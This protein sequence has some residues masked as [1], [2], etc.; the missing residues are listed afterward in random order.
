[1]I[2]ILLL[3]FIL[4]FFSIEIYI[5][6]PIKFLNDQ[7]QDICGAPALLSALLRSAS[8]AS[9]ASVISL[10]AGDQTNKSGE[11][12]VTRLSSLPSVA[13]FFSS[14]LSQVDARSKG[15]SKQSDVSGEGF[16]KQ[17]LG[18]SR[19]YTEAACRLLDRYP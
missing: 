10:F 4:L 5:Y 16:V 12:E 7:R 2:I 3:L 17:L 13:S 9:D 19:P 8:R 11:G 1:M 14:V 18:V 6:F 15:K